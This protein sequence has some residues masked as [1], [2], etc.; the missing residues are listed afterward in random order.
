MKL[1]QQEVV[2][3]EMGHPV[4]RPLSLSLAAVRNCPDK[5]AAA[6]CN[7]RD[8]GLSAAAR[9]QAGGRRGRP[10]ARQLAKKDLRNV[11]NILGG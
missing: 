8:N 7:W 1:S 5:D 10:Q 9:S 3:N 4:D 6:Y 2:T 11:R